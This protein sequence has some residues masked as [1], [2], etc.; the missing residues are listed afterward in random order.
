MHV[1]IEHESSPTRY[2]DR[3]RQNQSDKALG[4]LKYCRRTLLA[5]FTTVRDLGGTGVNVSLRNAINK[6]EVIGPRIYT[7]E[8][9]IATTGG[10][11]DPTNGVRD[12]LKGDPGPKE[13]VINSVEDAKKA[14]RQRYKNGADCI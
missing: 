9:A 1:H 7:A 5:G 4:A 14:V 3:F 13:G 2:M 12:D 6:G 8:K 10:H 11:A